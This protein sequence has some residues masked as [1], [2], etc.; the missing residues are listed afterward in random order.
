MTQT[1]EILPF[2]RKEPGTNLSRY[3]GY[4][5]ELL[6]C[7]PQSSSHSNSPPIKPPFISPPLSH[8]Q[9]YAK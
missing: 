4:L 3:T 2:I 5:T 8:T 1:V 9:V 7:F 6:R